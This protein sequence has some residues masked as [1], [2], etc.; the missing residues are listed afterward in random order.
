MMPT[1]TLLQVYNANMIVVSTL[2][3]ESMTSHIIVHI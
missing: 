1:S 3:Q 2:Y